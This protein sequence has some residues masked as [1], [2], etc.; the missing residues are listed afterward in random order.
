MLP[1]LESNAGKCTTTQKIYYQ[2]ETTWELLRMPNWTEL[3]EKKKILTKRNQ[4]IGLIAAKMN[5]IQEAKIAHNM[6]VCQVATFSPICISI[7]LKE[8]ASVDKPIL[9]VYHYQLKFMPSDA[10]HNMFLSEKGV[11]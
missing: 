5:S 10:K 11:D 2:Q 9:K 8:C 7:S 6:L 3:M 4:R 1:S